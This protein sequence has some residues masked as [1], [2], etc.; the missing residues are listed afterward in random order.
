[1]QEQ[2]NTQQRHIDEVQLDLKDLFIILWEKKILIVATT[3]IVTL[4]A[5]VYAFTKTPIYEAKALIEIGN[6]KSSNNNNNNKVL[7]SNPIELSQKLSLIFIDSFKNIKDKKS[8]I[9]SVTIPKKSNTMLEIQAEAISNELAENSIQTLLKY[10]QTQ[11][12]F[13]LNDVKNRREIEIKNIDETI[14]QIEDKEVKLLS[15]KINLKTLRKKEYKSQLQQ[16]DTI[17]KKVQKNNPTLAALQI[18]QKTSISNSIAVLNIN[19]LEL[20]NKKNTL[21]TTTI[22]TLIEKRNLLQSM[23][24]PYNYKNSQIIGKILINDFATK[25]KKK[26]IIIVAFI[27]GF[28]LSIFLVFFLQ[29]IRSM[30]EEDN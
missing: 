29:F 17:I 15:D 12:A 13:I 3:I 16:I 27:T 10:I 20:K 22:N 1:M 9:T 18:M 4:L 23:L 21:A 25:P 28:M 7:L 6:Y 8:E 19:I 30:K 14:K 5:G 2:N 26:L 11:D 24:L